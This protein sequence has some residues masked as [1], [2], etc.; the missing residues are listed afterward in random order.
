MEKE[1]IVCVPGPWENRKYLIEAIITSTRGEFMWA[2]M[3]LANP[4][5]KDHVTLELSDPDELMLQSFKLGG[6]GKITSE[7]L[8]AIA[9]H[10]STAY[11][12][13]ALNILSE[14]ARLL[15][16]TEVLFKCGGI[17]VKLETSGIAHEWERWFEL[18]GSTNP[19]DTYCACVVLVGDERFYYSC[20]MQHFGLPDVQVS[21]N[22]D[23][24]QAADLMNQFNYWQIVEKPVL[25]AGHTFSLT[26][27][28]DR[29]RLSRVQDKR[30]S[31]D[32][33]FHNSNGIWELRSD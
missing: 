1:I 26:P 21:N 23:A 18:L 30:H 6:Q 14:K 2:G 8:E 33:P 10:K 12:H 31:E 5:G 13:F 11:L 16:F 22:I 7:T 3:I 28:S 24:E 20:G 15:R 19:F 29:F 27:D 17:A 9:Q 4:K 25:E 32:D